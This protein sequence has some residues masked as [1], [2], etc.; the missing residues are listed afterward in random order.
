MPAHEHPPQLHHLLRQV[1]KGWLVGSSDAAVTFTYILGICFVTGM[2]GMM[3]TDWNTQLVLW[4]CCT[5]FAVIAMLVAAIIRDDFEARLVNHLRYTTGNTGGRTFR[6]APDTFRGSLMP[7][8]SAFEL[9]QP[10][11]GTPRQ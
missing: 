6:H 11:G 1:D 5:G 4:L 9:L 2:F 3:A 8:I 10:I 7:R